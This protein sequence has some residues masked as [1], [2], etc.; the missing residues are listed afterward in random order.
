M[1][2]LDA[3]RMVGSACLIVSASLFAGC[4]DDQDPDGAAELLGR[5]R[6]EDY[7]SWA[8]APGWESPRS[9]SAPHGDEVLIF[10][11]AAVVEAL[12]AEQSLSEW[13]MGSL[14]AKDGFEDGDIVLISAMEKR[15][16]G[17]FWAEW[18]GDG[19][20]KYSGKPDLCIDCHD[21][22]QDYVRA[23]ALP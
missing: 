12:A 18:D 9:S 3:P 11:N 17:W 7:Q 16:G 1:R 19:E 23:F 22:G 8:R 13:P 2:W 14:I 6:A 21:A 10:L 5:M 4:G 20:S 15:E